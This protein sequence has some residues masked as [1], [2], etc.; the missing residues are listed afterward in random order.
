MYTGKLCTERN[1]IKLHAF[2]VL[3]EIHFSRKF[4]FNINDLA[5]IMY[6]IY[7]YIIYYNIRGECYY[8]ARGRAQGGSRM[9]KQLSILG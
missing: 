2:V 1:T 9:Y 3:Y 8:T 7:I 4:L 5:I 6:N